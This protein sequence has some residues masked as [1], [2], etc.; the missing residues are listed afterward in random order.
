MSIIKL[1]KHV[2]QHLYNRELVNTSKAGIARNHRFFFFSLAQHHLRMKVT[3]SLLIRCCFCFYSREQ[4]SPSCG[5]TVRNKYTKKK[6][7]VNLDLTRLSLAVSSIHFQTKN[8]LL[9]VV[10]WPEAKTAA[11][12]SFSD[13]TSAQSGDKPKPWRGPEEEATQITTTTIQGFGG[14]R[15]S[16]GHCLALFSYFML[17]L[18]L[19]LGCRWH[20]SEQRSREKNTSNVSAKFSSMCLLF[21]V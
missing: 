5:S 12:P 15:G 18:K 10:S 6:T 7:N 19:F 13:K 2:G 3:R 20:F 17:L 4:C 1:L 11:L 21:K 16:H 14:A 9:W 8:K